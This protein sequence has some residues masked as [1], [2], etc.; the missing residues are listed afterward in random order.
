MNR[1]R[2]GRAQT[3]LPA[4][5]VALV[6][7]TVVT[8]LGLGIADSAIAGADRAPDER[9]VAAAV[10]A[11][12]VAADGPLA[13]RASVLSGPRVDGF[14]GA[15]LQSE[16]GA[17]DQYT[18]SVRLDG[19]V[20]ATTGDAGGGPSNARATGSAPRAPDRTAMDRL[21]LVERTKSASVEPES[22]TV[23]LPRRATS[24]TLT[25]SPTNGSAVRTVRVNERVRLHNDSGLHGTTEIELTPYET[26]RLRFQT[27]GAISEGSIRVSYETPRTRK[28]TLAVTV[29]G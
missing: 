11:Q 19:R 25:F 21:V 20:I 5:A 7:L 12:L 24:A 9:R 17:A 2:P 27:A 10:A 29:N 6:L 15:T 14:D 26:T 22:P 23:T 28:A 4:V 1:G 13:E 18:V 8:A 3:T 16:I